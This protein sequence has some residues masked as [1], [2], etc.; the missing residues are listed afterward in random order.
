MCCHGNC[1]VVSLWLCS[2]TCTCYWP[3]IF[4]TNTTSHN[5]LKFR[6]LLG[7]DL[8]VYSRKVYSHQHWDCIRICSSLQLHRDIWHFFPSSWKLNVQKFAIR[9]KT[10]KM[11]VILLMG[12]GSGRQIADWDRYLISSVQSLNNWGK[13][14]LKCSDKCTRNTSLSIPWYIMYKMTEKCIKTEI[15][16]HNV[17]FEA[18][19]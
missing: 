18:A 5:Y 10:W 15:E 4:N 17:P 9:F 11:Y 12:I 19:F 6:K 7:S 8:I 3:I 2:I 16:S 14:H 1:N 13:I